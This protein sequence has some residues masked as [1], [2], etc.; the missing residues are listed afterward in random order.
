ML[1]CSAAVETKKIPL[2]TLPTSDYE[3]MAGMSN[4]R[5]IGVLRSAVLTPDR[6]GRFTPRPPEEHDAYT[7]RHRTN[8]IDI[9]LYREGAEVFHIKF[10]AAEEY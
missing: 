2:L 4:T 8:C 6:I 9:L 7:V 1:V 5:L 10:V 3:Q